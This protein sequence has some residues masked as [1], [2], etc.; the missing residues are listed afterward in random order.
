V[1]L[2]N[3]SYECALMSVILCGVQES[4]VDATRQLV[5]RELQGRSSRGSIGSQGTVS[6]L[7]QPARCAQKYAACVHLARSL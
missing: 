4:K 3:H 5:Q 2:V 1:P 6:N 7:A